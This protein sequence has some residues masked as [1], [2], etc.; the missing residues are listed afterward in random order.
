MTPVAMR[1]PAAGSMRS[2]LGLSL[3]LHGSLI[4]LTIVIGWRGRPVEAPVYSVNLVAAPPGERAIG[5]VMDTPP[6]LDAPPEPP[7]RAERAPDERTI[8]TKKPAQS[9]R[10]QPAR[11]APTPN[12]RSARRDESAARAGGGPTGGKGAD[13]ANV[14]TEGIQFPYPAYL[15]NIVRQIALRFK[16][17]NPGALRAEVVFLIR[18]DGS[19]TGFQFRQRSGVYAFDLEAQGAVEAASSSFGPLPDGFRDD[20]LTVIFA[21]DPQLIR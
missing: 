18:R 11:A 15:E 10:K 21:F 5:T 20:V 2:S 16:P 1:R 17:R 6:A 13:V 19:V 14:R 7:K 9:A 12:A 3:I 8:P 4:A